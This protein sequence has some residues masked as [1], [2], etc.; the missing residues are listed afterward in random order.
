MFAHA[1]GASFDTLR[2]AMI[3]VINF[4]TGGIGCVSTNRVGIASGTGCRRR[5]FFALRA[6]GLVF[7]F[8]SA[9]TVNGIREIG[10]Q[11]IKQEAVSIPLS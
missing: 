6:R 2:R 4:G 10:M 5:A 9:A 7:T 8:G 11:G 1:I 3:S